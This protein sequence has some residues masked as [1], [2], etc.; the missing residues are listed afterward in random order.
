MT[1]MRRP[2]PLIGISMPSSAGLGRPSF[3]VSPLTPL[4]KFGQIGYYRE[5][6]STGSCGNPWKPVDA[7]AKSL[8][9]TAKCSTGLHF[10]YTG[11]P[12]FYT[13]YPVFYTRPIFRFL[14]SSLCISFFLKEKKEYIEAKHQNA[15]PRVTTIAYFLSHGFLTIF[16]RT[17]GWFLGQLSFQINALILPEPAI[18]GS[19]A[20]LPV[21]G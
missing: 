16:H 18:H 14:V 10:F 8:I 3:R 13:D 11:S 6:G 20:N 19:T 5:G 12:V 21:G 4:K 7:V 9:Y 17:R 15:H 2:V 1:A